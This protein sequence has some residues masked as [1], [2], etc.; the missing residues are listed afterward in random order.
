MVVYSDANGMTIAFAHQYGLPDGT[1]IQSRGR[2]TR[3]DPKFIFEDGVR[4]KYDP[5]LDAPKLA[6]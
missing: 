6:P 4:Y 5:K 2:Q 3:A 1:P